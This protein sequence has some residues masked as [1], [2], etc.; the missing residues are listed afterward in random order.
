MIDGDADNGTYE[1]FEFIFAAQVDKG[2]CKDRYMSNLM[3]YPP[4]GLGTSG[5]WT[6]F[7]LVNS[8]VKNMS[9]AYFGNS[10]IKSGANTTE[11]YYQTFKLLQYYYVV[12]EYKLADLPSQLVMD[13]GETISRS[14]NTLTGVDGNTVNIVMSDIEAR[15]GI[16]HVI[17]GPLHPTNPNDYVYKSESYLYT[18]GSENGDKEGDNPYQ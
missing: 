17:D 14:G 10:S 1:F 2:V 13:N 7:V 5:K 4:P 6:V 9:S 11:E 15:N 18:Y 8:E 12:G 3:T 16:I